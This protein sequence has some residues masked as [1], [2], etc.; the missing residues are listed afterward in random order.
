MYTVEAGA[1]GSTSRRYD[2]L[3]K[4]GDHADGLVGRTYRPGGSPLL[5]AALA[6]PW[7][8]PPDAGTADLWPFAELTPRPVERDARA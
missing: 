4:R 1:R 2:P 5:R 7:V 8:E 6:G 3:R